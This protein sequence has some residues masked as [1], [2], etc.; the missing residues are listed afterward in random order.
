ME[1]F[2]VRDL[3]AKGKYLIDDQFLNG[4]A[5][6]VEKYA[7]GV[8]NSLCRHAGKDQK[9]WPSINKIS[10]ELGFG[11]DSVIQGIKRLEFW[12]IIKK[13]RIGKTVNNRYFLLDKKSWKPVSEVAM[14]DFSEVAGADF[15]S[16][17]QR[18][19]QSSA[20][21]SNSKETHSKVTDAP[22]SDPP[23]DITY[24]TDEDMTPIGEVKKRI[25]R[26]DGYK[27]EQTNPLLK[28][29]EQRMGKKFVNP[30]K[31][32]TAISK[33]LHAGYSTEAIQAAWDNLE[34]DDYWIDKGF[35][36]MT[37]ANQIEKHKAKGKKKENPQPVYSEPPP[38]P[39]KLTAEEK[40]Q[41]EINIEK[42]RQNLRDKGILHK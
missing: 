15:T 1:N 31:Q 19:H 4:Y 5:R 17:L 11:R 24:E 18:L 6:F 12:K 23:E 22:A 29:G 21:T 34:F 27:G 10:E 42:V 2:E 30:L 14:A 35:D 3:R 38:P 36:F 40:K 39:K 16:R 32:K 8:Y 13:Q 37:V 7:V 28:W 25:A 20:P 41:G 26:A 9:S 33:M